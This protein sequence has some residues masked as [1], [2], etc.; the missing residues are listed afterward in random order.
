MEFAGAACGTRTHDLFITRV[1][2]LVGR[3]AHLGLCV[4]Q[5]LTA[6]ASLS[7]RDVSCADRAPSGNQSA[8]IAVQLRGGKFLLCLVE[9]GGVGL[10][11]GVADGA[12]EVH[13]SLELLH[14]DPQ[15]VHPLLMGKV[16]VGSS[17]A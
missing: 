1:P 13:D 9:G 8:S 14:S 10:Q 6:L 7:S 15:I 16:R 12:F 17:T 4:S 2:D 11:V 5:E 3:G